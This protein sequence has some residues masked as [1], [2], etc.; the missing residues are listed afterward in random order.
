MTQSKDRPCRTSPT[1]GRRVFARH[2][3]SPGRGATR[4]TAGVNNVSDARPPTIDN[5]RALNTDESAYDFIGRQ[6]YLRRGQ[7]S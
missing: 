3:R 6:F 1:T 4:I 7:R 5:G 2:A